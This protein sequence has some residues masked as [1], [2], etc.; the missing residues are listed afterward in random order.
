MAELDE[1]A[2]NGGSCDDLYDWID[3]R[4]VNARQILDAEG[5]TF[6]GSGLA[7]FGTVESWELMNGC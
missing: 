7:V 2:A 6:L 4:Y 1:L 5:M 3:G